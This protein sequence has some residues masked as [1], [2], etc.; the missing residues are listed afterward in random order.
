LPFSRDRAW[1]LSR[2]V[3][4]LA[5][6]EDEAEPNPFSLLN[7]PENSLENHYLC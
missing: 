2:T 1:T 7:S 5:I 4:V 3:E 6:V